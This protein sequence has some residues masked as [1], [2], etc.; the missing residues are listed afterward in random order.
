MDV[1]LFLLAVGFFIAITRSYDRGYERGRE[2]GLE[3]ARR[4]G[5][6]P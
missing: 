6:E 5:W 1:V 4:R 2:A 3:E